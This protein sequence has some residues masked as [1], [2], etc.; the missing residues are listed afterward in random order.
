MNTRR[1]FCQMTTAHLPTV[2]ILNKLRTFTVRS[3]LNKWVLSVG[4]RCALVFH[5]VRSRIDPD[6]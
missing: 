6:M 2:K 4:K 3:K 5:C 1:H